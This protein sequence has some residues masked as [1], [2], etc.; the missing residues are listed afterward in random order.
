[1]HRG[2]VSGKAFAGVDVRAMYSH[3]RRQA[4]VD[5]LDT[6]LPCTKSDIPRYIMYPTFRSTVILSPK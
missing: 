5:C 1:M 3:D 6:Y 4:A 2:V